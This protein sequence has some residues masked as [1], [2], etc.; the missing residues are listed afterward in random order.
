MHE[1]VI[2]PNWPSCLS[3]L[4]WSHDC[5]LALA[6]GETVELLVGTASPHLMWLPAKRCTDSS[7]ERRQ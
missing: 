3:S 7:P 4:A 5:I 1:A 6:A 2:L